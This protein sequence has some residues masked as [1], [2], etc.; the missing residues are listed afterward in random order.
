M[1]ERTVDDV[2]DEL[3]ER[4]EDRL[5]LLQVVGTAPMMHVTRD[6]ILDWIEEERQRERAAFGVVGQGSPSAEMLR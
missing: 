4:A 2:M 6:A 3:E 5:K 1:G